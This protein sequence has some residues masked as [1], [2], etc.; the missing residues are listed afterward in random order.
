MT[1]PESGTQPPKRASTIGG[2]WPNA[3]VENFHEVPGASSAELGAW[4][5]TD[6]LSYAPGDVVRVHTST[7]AAQYDVRIYRDG[8]EEVEVRAWQSLAGRF[9]PTPADASVK[10]CGWPTALEFDVPTAWRSG[11]YIAHITARGADDSRIDHHFP[12]AIRALR[13]SAPDALLLI[14]CT[15][16]WVAYN[17]WGG[18]N[19]YEGIAGD[20]GNRASPMLSTLRPFSRGFAWL[21][22]GAPR[23]PLRNPPGL[24][25]A[26]RYPHM[27]W[28]Y[29]N[30]FSKK[31]ASAGWATYE[32]HFVAWAEAQGF[33]VDVA[34]Q[35]DLHRDAALLDG[36]TGVVLV[37]HD[38]YWSWEMRDAI[39]T[40]IEDGG[41]V[42]RFAGNFL[43]QI[44]I[45]ADGTRQVGYKTNA[46]AADPV[47]HTDRRHLLTTAWEDTAVARP[48]ALTFGLNGSCGIYAGWGACVPRGSGGFTVY[49]PEHW[50]F[51][52]TDLYYGDQLGADA[53]VF[54]Y[55]VDGCDY[56]F[57]DGLPYATGV[58]GAPDNL[59]ILA[60]GVA[61]TAEADHRNPGSVFFIGDLDAQ[62]IAHQ[63]LR[64]TDEAAIDRVRRGSGM[65]ACFDRG[66]GSVFNV[67]SCEW[68]AGLIARDPFVERLTKNVLLR[69]TQPAAPQT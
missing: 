65:I 41:H 68:V 23:I 39:D 7:T 54:G 13:P 35:H 25:D 61:T 4:I 43:W 28:A 14:T 8:A 67:G 64:R 58:D 27:E 33:T 46:E 36:Y 15:A 47:R 22:K 19:F 59:Q 49:R 34:T 57:R 26:P 32:R 37:G 21:P 3:T 31:Y 9:H 17:D 30:G 60:M 2:V 42:A 6:K 63:R 62:M 11:G 52:G 38:E 12:F 51:E 20:T 45:E 18:S 24:G 44:R 29:A 40:Y 53:K 56:T 1:S 55:E 69:L 50:A 66:K 10:G 16:T 48:G 5:Y